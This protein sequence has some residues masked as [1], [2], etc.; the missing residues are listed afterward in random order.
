MVCD[1][2][3]N[4]FWRQGISTP[5]SW[6]ILSNALSRYTYIMRAVISTLLAHDNGQRRL[7]RHPTARQLN[8]LTGARGTGAFV[9]KSRVLAKSAVERY[10]WLE[11]GEGYLIRSSSHKGPTTLHD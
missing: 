8:H 10:P 6:C 9:P 2:T 4:T 7:R 1:D 11:S 5:G 3:Q